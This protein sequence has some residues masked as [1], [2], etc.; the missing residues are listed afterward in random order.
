[1]WPWRTRSDEDF[2]EELHDHILRETQ[3]LVEEEGLNFAA[4]KA[5]ALRSFGN[6]TKTRERFYER[7]RMAW[8]DDL[9]RDTAYAIRNL[10]RHPGFAA[11]TILTLAV[12]IGATT[13]IYSV[14]NSILLQPLPFRNSDR[15]VRVVENRVAGTRRMFQRGVTYQE[16]VEWRARATTLSG[17]AAVISLPLR[18]TRTSEGT[19]SFSGSMVSGDMFS[20]LGASAMLGRTLGPADE[21]HP[22]VLVLSFEA[23]QR[24]FHSDPSILGKAIEIRA[25]A[26]APQSAWVEGKIQSRLLTVVGV[27]PADFTFPTGR[28][29]FLTP[30]ALDPSKPSPRVTMIAYVKDGVS[31]DTATDEANRIG[32]AIT[33]PLP[34]DT[35][36]LPGQ[37]FE[38]LQLKDQLVSE[39]R[40]ALR[41]FL[42][43][44][45]VVLLVVCANV[46]NLLLAR[47][48]TRQREVAIRLAIGATRGRIV[49]HIFAECAVLAFIGGLLGAALGAGGVMLV[50]QLATIDAPGV[51]RSFF[52][53]TIL[54]R[55]D[56]VGVDLRIT[57]IAF[58]LAAAT[59]VVF[60]LLPALHFSRTN[61]RLTIGSRNGSSGRRDGGIRAALAIGQHVMATVLLV[62]AGLLVKSF[63]KLSTSPQGY[64]PSNVLTFQL[65]LPDQYPLQRKI[66]TIE[67]LLT[68]LRLAPNVEAAGF[69]RHGV[70]MGEELMVGTFVPANR[71][72]DEMRK[73]PE[74]PRVRAVSPG[75]MK[76]MS[77][78]MVSGRELNESDG[79]AAAPVIMINQTLARH[80]FGSQ[81]AVGQIVDWHVEKARMQ[82]T[83]VGIVEDVRNEGLA[84]EV[85]PEV[86]VDY[87]QYLSLSDKWGESVAGQH[88]LIMGFLS[89]AVR[90]TNEPALAVPAVRQIVSAVD[91]SVGIDSILPM[92]RM[93]AHTLARERFY[94]VMLGTFSGVAALLATIGIYGVLAYLVVQ[95]TQEIGIRMALGAQRA[96]VLGLVMRRGLALTTAGIVLGLAGAAAGTRLLEGMLFGI[97]PLDPATFIAV[98]SVFAMV[99]MC[100]SYVPARRATAVNPVVA[101]RTE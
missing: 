101:L 41:L 59:C 16:F 37:R 67:S 32:A 85:Y 35:P 95:R 20:M 47:G 30:I 69:A 76:A 73:Q 56:E 24:L 28:P 38:I 3:R 7:G 61:H 84:A 36:A 64:D 45:A 29:N 75:F 25:I 50:K 94:A 23:W 82:M 77:I 57:A 46:A 92:E 66:D 86:F 62:G 89:F 55:A 43:A 79:P 34:A 51:L 40:P 68:K 99:A 11:T 96:Q 81:R 14:V 60:G 48:T 58:A 78:R 8:L 15:M 4:A 72:L 91:A 54:P 13:A 98:S 83:V 80:Y 65:V 71:T 74:L 53:A 18:T 22:D 12:G 2:A 26:N 6:L 1:M 5:K 10:R 100:A 87:R 63:L 33:P 21:S 9:R 44:V 31:F 97:T 93:V 90:T 52:G 49:R 42:A 27:L 19:T 39:M 88:E 17:A 70:L